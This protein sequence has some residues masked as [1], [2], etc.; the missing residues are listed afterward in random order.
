MQLA[1]I[2]V[3]LLERAAS[4]WSGVGVS[5]AGSAPRAVPR[6][7]TA[8]LRDESERKDL[9]A[10]LFGEKD[11][12]R[13]SSRSDQSVATKASAEPEMRMLVEGIQTLE[14]GGVRLVDVDM[15]PGPL[16]L[17]LAPLLSDSQLLCVRVN[18]PLGALCSRM[19]RSTV[20]TVQLLWPNYLRA[21]RRA[22]QWA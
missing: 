2:V 15:A 7:R 18:M 17:S 4:S 16:E 21:Q 20:M 3:L 13:I 8:L 1:L 11:A 6:V 19:A 5:K 22:R 14:W 12:E 10:Q 9:L